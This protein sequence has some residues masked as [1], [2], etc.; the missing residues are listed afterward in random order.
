M[1]TILEPRP[2]D[3][4]VVLAAKIKALEERI[5]RLEKGVVIPVSVGLPLNTGQGR[6]GSMAADSGTS[7]LY[8]K[9]NGI[10]RYVTV[11]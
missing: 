11:T 7:R 5:A 3:P 4:A 8:V 1:A 6:E 2:P 10:W 9:I